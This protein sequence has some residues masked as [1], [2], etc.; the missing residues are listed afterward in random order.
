MIFMLLTVIMAVIVVIFLLWPLFSKKEQ[1]NRVKRDAVNI[2]SAAARLSELK[3]ELEDG[4]INE[5]QFQYYQRELETV[6]L[7]DLS[8]SLAIK[9]QD[10]KGNKILAFIVALIVPL[11]SFATYNQLGNEM[12]FS[13]Q[14]TQIT[15]ES[16]L[17]TEEIEKMLA[18]L[19]K[20]VQENPDDIEG[21]IALGQVYIEL[22]RY[23]DAT[24]V[25]REL[26]Q[27][28]P[29]EPDIL[30][31]FAEVLARSHGNR[32]SGK[33]TEL[34]YQALKIAPKHGRA[35]WL[36]GF[37]E[38]QVDNKAGALTH[39]R[40]LLTGME[41]DSEA[42]QQLE[43]LIYEVDGVEST[44]KTVITDQTSD[45]K[46]SLQVKVS[47]LPE[48]LAKVD[49]ETTMF[50]YARASEGP[51][52]PLAVY[53]GLA[54][55]LPVTVTLDDSMAMMPQMSLS[56][57]QKVIVGARLSSNG[58]PQGQSG[59]YEGQSAVIKVSTNSVVEI[60]IDS[61]KP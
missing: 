40:N 27:L 39:W 52:M 3:L 34:L 57:F 16:A 38:Q 48:L 33:P 1:L 21:R 41:T 26:N 30:V 22:E 45:T 23:S 50:I 8:H 24:I 9:T 36:A 18:V 54:K 58:Q 25:F 60:L 55:E 7:E 53:R 14:N 5:K 43:N 51:P 17:A 42:Y 28:R 29:N 32:L 31:N 19:E 47:L 2:E 12:A 13:E 37:A 4:L 15:N 59:D 6:A 49:P 61:I 10:R 11:F 46:Q 56:N 20:N 35:L 44:S